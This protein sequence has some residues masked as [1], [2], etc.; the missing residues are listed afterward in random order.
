[1]TACWHNNWDA[2]VDEINQPAGR[3]RIGR[4]V[5]SRRESGW[6]EEQLARDDERRDAIDRIYA[7]CR[8]DGYRANEVVHA[9]VRDLSSE[10]RQLVEIEVRP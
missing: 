4:W 3:R 1:M 7:R 6:S 9:I 2:L 10:M 8:R 5:V